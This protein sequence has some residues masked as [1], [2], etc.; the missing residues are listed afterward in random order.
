MTAPRFTRF[1][2]HGSSETGLQLWETI[3]PATLSSG[4]PVQRGHIYHED[5]GK[6]L[7]VGVWDCTAMTGLFEPYPVNE[8]MLLL[9]GS[10]TIVGANGDEATVNAGEAFV[11]PKGLPCTW[12]QEGYVRKYF[13]IFDDPSGRAPGDTSVLKVILPQP[14]GPAGGMAEVASPDGPGGG[15]VFRPSTI[16]SISRT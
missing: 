1:G 4:A 15:G 12:K 13:M 5:A 7:M 10:V 14:A 3:D 2:P 16:T 11:L 6:G 9:E 8:Y